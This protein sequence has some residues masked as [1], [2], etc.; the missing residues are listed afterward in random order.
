MTNKDTDDILKNSEYG[1]RP[2]KEKEESP[3]YLFWVFVAA[4]MWVVAIWLLIEYLS[5]RN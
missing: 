4:P 3:P 5:K 1:R 2:K